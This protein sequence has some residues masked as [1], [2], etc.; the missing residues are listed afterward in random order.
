MQG[1]AE[2]DMM[3]KK[4]NKINEHNKY[5]IVPQAM[6]DTVNPVASAYRKTTK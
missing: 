1:K 3:D 2:I 5:T 6:T 4:R